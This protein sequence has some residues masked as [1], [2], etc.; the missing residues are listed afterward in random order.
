MVVRGADDMTDKK[1]TYDIFP[2]GAGFYANCNGHHVGEI[3]FVRV[4][5]DK[6]II[7]YTAVTEQYRHASIGLNLV[8]CVANVARNQKRKVITMCPFAAA[9]FSKYPEFDDVRFLRAR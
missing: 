2:N 5:A 6:M 8:R 3:T 7:D 1:I 4:G 9:M